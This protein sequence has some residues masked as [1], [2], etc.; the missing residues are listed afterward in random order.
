MQ[1]TD[2]SQRT[3]TQ[4]ASDRG[5]LSLAV[6]SKGGAYVAGGKAGGLIEIASDSGRCVTLVFQ[7]A[8]TYDL[9]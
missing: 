8:I 9:L 4:A 7:Q 1:C 3:T 5:L 2:C 6:E